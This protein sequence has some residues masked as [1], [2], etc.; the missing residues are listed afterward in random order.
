MP[1]VS[2]HPNAARLISKK[3]SFRLLRPKKARQLSKPKPAANPHF[4]A[5]WV[6]FLT[7]DAGKDSSQKLV[8]AVILFSRVYDDF[9]VAR[10]LLSYF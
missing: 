9:R 1:A 10:I 7:I 4:S 5:G 3:Q 6:N 2:V 8:A